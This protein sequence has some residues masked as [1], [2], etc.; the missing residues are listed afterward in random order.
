M[1]SIKC[2]K[3]GLVNFAAA[4]QCKRCG[5]AF[6]PGA[7]G[8]VPRPASTVGAPAPSPGRASTSQG[9]G[10]S[11]ALYYRESGEVALLGL[12]AGL[13]GGLAAGAVAA[14]V[15]SYFIYY[16]PFIYLSFLGTVGFA[17]VDGF[18]VAGLMRWGKMRSTFFCVVGAALVTC[19][20]YYLSW[21]VWVALV[22][23]DKELS[24][25]SLEL[26]QNPSALWALTGL[27]AEKGAWNIRG[28][29]VSGAALWA[30]W[31]VEA[32]IVL[33]GAPAMAWGMMNADPFCESCEKWCE[34]DQDVLSVAAAEESELRRR[35]EAK[36]F[37]YLATVGPRPG[38]APEWYRFD[39][40]RCTGCGETNT[41]SVMRAKLKIDS[42]GNASVGTSSFME[43][44]LLSPSEAG[45]L[46]R[47]GQE[48]ASVR[49]AAG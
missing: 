21:A 43:K 34:E 41:L 37:A 39:L 5:A 27:I 4:E 29:T 45:D 46:R 35:V 6:S 32:L 47:L 7:E 8:R 19:V 15:Y 23:S 36:D 49:P 25:P 3:C 26:A 24:V 31:G 40:H 17:L 11:D 14:F 12:G 16:M 30:V 20:S 13:L 10:G 9:V 33:V 38:G 1:N 48:L 44:L 22:V 42:K 2:V 18:A 28:L